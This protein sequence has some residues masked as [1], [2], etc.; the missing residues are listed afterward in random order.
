MSVPISKLVNPHATDVAAPPDDPPGTR[1]NDHGLFVVPK[2][3]L[4]V[5]RSPDH[6]GTLVLP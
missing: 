5:W 1:S 6:R 3:S 4:Y 2:I